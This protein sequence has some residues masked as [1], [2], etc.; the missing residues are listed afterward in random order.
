M[1]VLMGCQTATLAVNKWGLES[2]LRVSS[3]QSAGT[4][5]YGAARAVEESRKSTNA[6]LAGT[7]ATNLAL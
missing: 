1:Q 3:V 7:K 6:L 4:Q 5:R 2:C